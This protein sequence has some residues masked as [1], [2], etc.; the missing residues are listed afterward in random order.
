MDIMDINRDRS[1]NVGRQKLIMGNW[2]MNGSEKF[3]QDFLSDLVKGLELGLSNKNIKPEISLAICPPSVYLKQAMAEIQAKNKD[4]N[5]L[6]IKIHVGA[7]D[8]SS[9]EGS[10]AYTGEIS[11][12]MLKDLGC[13]YVLVGHSERRQYHQESNELVA[14]K[15]LSALKAGL[16]PVICVGESLKERESNQ[17]KLIISGQLEAVFNL[18]S[19]EL[20]KNSVI[21]Y[22][23]VW[24]IGTGLAATKEQVQEV[25][26]FIREKLADYH[27]DLAPRFQIL[28]GGS[29]KPANAGEILALTD[30]DG[31]LIGGASLKAEE[32]LSICR[33]A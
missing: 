6:K 23:P 12:A 2:K 9:H 17:T 29:L 31:G 10:G 18:I 3:T 14:Q 20:F 25:H 11:G 19:P 1:M 4:N 21:A 33:S 30:V 16:M 5:N 32:F 7:Q 8:L 22:E 24:A 27:L 26:A 15:A 13:K 28:Y